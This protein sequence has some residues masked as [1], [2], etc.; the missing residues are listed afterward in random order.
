MSQYTYS[1]KNTT[2]FS[3]NRHDIFVHTARKV[4]K[5]RMKSCFCLKETQ[6]QKLQ[7]WNGNSISDIE[8]DDN[9]ITKW[10]LL[11]SCHFDEIFTYLK[12]INGNRTL[13]KIQHPV[14]FTDSASYVIIVYFCVPGIYKVTEQLFS[15]ALL[16]CIFVFD[17]QMYKEHTEIL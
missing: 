16:L 1:V 11:C 14:F 7:D 9:H 10:C 13:I 4:R 2:C 15:I 3:S 8:C 5:K 17:S 6:A 12:V